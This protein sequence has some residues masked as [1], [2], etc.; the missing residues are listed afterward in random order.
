[1]QCT[2]MC[3]HSTDKRITISIEI[4]SVLITMLLHACQEPGQRFHKSIIVHNSIPFISLK[5]SFRISIMFCQNNCI[6]ICFFY[7]FPEIFPELMVK[8]IAV[9]QICCYIQSP[10]IYIVRRRN[11]FLSY[12]QNIVIKLPG[13][14]II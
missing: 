13:A 8:F 7:R 10:S 14:F 5:P 4:L 12:M 11:P 3:F 2:H 6:G 1:M 9:S